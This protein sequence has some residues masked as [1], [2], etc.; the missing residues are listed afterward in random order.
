MQSCTL[1]VTSV[2]HE[3]HLDDQPQPVV[4]ANPASSGSQP[5]LKVDDSAQGLGD[6]P[7]RLIRSLSGVVLIWSAV[8]LCD[9]VIDE[10]SGILLF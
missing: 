7:W 4:S 9:R 1:P 10:P 6:Y 2:D 3:E 8:L 5:T